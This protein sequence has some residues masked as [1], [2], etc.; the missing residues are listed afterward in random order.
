MGT[1]IYC[2]G[3]VYLAIADGGIDGDGGV[4]ELLWVKDFLNVGDDLGDV[5][6]L[7]NCDDND[8]DLLVVWSAYQRWW[9]S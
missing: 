4:R 7:D 9:R 2:L 3:L 8:R 1:T 6:V 5:D